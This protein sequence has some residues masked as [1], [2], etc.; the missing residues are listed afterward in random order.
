MG[1]LALHPQR[2]WK[3]IYMCV[4]IIRQEVTKW[5]KQDA[6]DSELKIDNRWTDYHYNA[7][8]K[9]VSAV[10]VSVCG[11]EEARMQETKCVFHVPHLIRAIG[12][13]WEFERMCYKYQGYTKLV[14]TTKIL[15]V[16]KRDALS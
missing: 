1:N 7:W 5:E 12:L 15:K 8:G 2:T 6:G 4:C 9:V 10:L 11:N 14:T 16:N 3:R 13:L